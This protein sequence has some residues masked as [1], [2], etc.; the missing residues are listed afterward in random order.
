[1]SLHHKKKINWPSEG[2][3]HYEPD[4]KIS[5]HISNELHTMR[6]VFK[7]PCS[8]LCSLSIA[9]GVLEGSRN[10][11]NR[12]TFWTD[13]LWQRTRSQRQ[14]RMQTELTRGCIVWRS[15]WCVE[16]WAHRQRINENV[17]AIIP[18]NSSPIRQIN[19][20]QASCNG[21]HK[22]RW[23]VWPERFWEVCQIGG[24][25]WWFV[26]DELSKYIGIL[27]ISCMLINKISVSLGGRWGKRRLRRTCMPRRGTSTC[28]LKS[29]S[30]NV[31]II[32]SNSRNA[33]KSV[34]AE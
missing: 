22:R 18:N 4:I 15:F 34:Q 10:I 3:L 16:F 1:M 8:G 14:T 17:V 2:Q 29:K 6:R 33:V 30:A 21:C 24:F 31:L 7:F 13:M 32:L 11:L 23:D 5:T 12:R 26:W 20:R 25:D 27:R 9:M 19:L 28:H